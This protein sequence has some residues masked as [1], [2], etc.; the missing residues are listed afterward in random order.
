M[1]RFT[2]EKI[3][4]LFLQRQITISELAREAGVAHQSAQKAV[5]G[6]PVSANIVN[7]IAAALGIDAV[8]Y[9][10]PTLNLR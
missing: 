5:N 4:P 6:L 7:R 10:A 3:L 9:L 8:S 2:R 1:F